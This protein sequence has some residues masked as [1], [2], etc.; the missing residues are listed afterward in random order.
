MRKKRGGHLV[1]ET[2]VYKYGYK[3]RNIKDCQ[4]LQKPRVKHGTESPVQPPERAQLC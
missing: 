3:P 1:T 4:C 2:D